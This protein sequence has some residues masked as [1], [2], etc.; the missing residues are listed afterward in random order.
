VNR[1]AT[2]YGVVFG[3]LTICVIAVFLSLLSRRN[4]KISRHRSVLNGLA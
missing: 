2:L 3:G 1:K 4:Y